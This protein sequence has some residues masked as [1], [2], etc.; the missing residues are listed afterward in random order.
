[1]DNDSTEAKN[2]P[3]IKEF[4]AL[5]EKTVGDGVLDFNHLK[6]SAFMK[7]WKNIIIY[8][9]DEDID[10]LVVVMFGSYISK[11]HEAD[12]TGKTL[13]EMGFGEKYDYTFALNMKIINGERRVYA[14]GNLYWKEREYRKWYLVKMPL[15][16]DG[17][18]NEVLSCMDIL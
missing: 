3:L 16:R 9:Y 11:M 8:R 17:K 10:D 15:Q 14:N 13:S 5:V 1:M 18:V 12:F 6:D 7:F 4:V 2:Q